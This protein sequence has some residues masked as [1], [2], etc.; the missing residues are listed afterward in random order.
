VWQPAS[1]KE[2]PNGE[3]TRIRSDTRE[4]EGADGRAIKSIPTTDICCRC[5]GD[6][7]GALGPGGIRTPHAGVLAMTRLSAVDRGCDA[8]ERHGRCHSDVFG[9]IL[10]RTFSTTQSVRV[11]QGRALVRCGG[12]DSYRAR[13]QKDD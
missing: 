11:P 5:L 6:L 8:I 12:C 3:D 2:H 13:Q 4:A 1:T 10:A 9:S 7:H